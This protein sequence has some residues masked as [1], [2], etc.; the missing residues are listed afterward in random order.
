MGQQ[1]EALKEAIQ[2]SPREFWENMCQ[3]AEA[4]KEESQKFLKVTREYR[5]MWGAD[6]AN[7]LPA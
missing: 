2:K 6:G 4:L 7:I 3:H 1:V 5:G